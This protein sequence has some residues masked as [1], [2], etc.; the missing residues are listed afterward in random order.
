LTPFLGQFRKIK[1]KKM[2]SNFFHL[3]KFFSSIF[4]FV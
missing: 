4:L 1:N 2:L 3:L